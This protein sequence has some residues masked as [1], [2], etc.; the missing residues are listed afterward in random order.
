MKIKV[1]GHYRTVRDATTGRVRQIWVAP[2]DKT[3]KQSR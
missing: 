3:I 1:Y 2:Y